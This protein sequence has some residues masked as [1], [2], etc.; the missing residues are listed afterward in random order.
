MTLADI[1]ITVFC[2]LVWLALILRVSRSE[3]TN[4]GPR[5]RA[6]NTQMRVRYAEKPLR[7]TA[8]AG[9][10]CAQNG[11]NHEWVETAIAFPAS[12]GAS[13]RSRVTW[14]VRDFGSKRIK[15]WV[16][17]ALVDRSPVVT[18]VEVTASP[19]PGVRWLRPRW[20]RRRIHALSRRG[21]T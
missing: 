2:A 3:A 21:P 6:F 1:F 16:T 20:M 5:S 13:A 15:I 8:S 9:T 10:Q 17:E 7:Y 4:A 19:A 12:S 14:F 18:W 11:L